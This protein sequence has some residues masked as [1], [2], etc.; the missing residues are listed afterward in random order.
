MVTQYKGDNMA[1]LKATPKNYA[2]ALTVLAGRES[3]RL[4]NNTYLENVAEYGEYT[5][6]I[7][8]R[9]HNTYVVVFYPHDG[10]VTLHTGGYRTVTTK[11]RINHFV[12]GAL[13]QKAC[14]WYYT[15]GHG[16]TVIFEDGLNVGA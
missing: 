12:S 1:K 6:K 4:G 11:E 5:G 8:V 3:V 14:Q 15:F 9:L 16:V 10:R 7:G 13:Y 2:E